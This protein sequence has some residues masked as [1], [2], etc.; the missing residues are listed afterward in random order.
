MNIPFVL[1][2]SEV[3]QEVTPRQFWLALLAIGIT[4]DAVVAQLAGNE[5]ALITVKKALSVSRHDPLVDAM[6]AMLGKTQ[7]EV[8][9]VFQLASTL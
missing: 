8:D 4:E 3:P 1:Y 2:P 7:E 6:A 5:A 9:A